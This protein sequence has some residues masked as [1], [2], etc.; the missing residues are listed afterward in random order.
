L[1]ITFVKAFAEFVSDQLIVRQL[2]HQSDLKIAT[3]QKI[4]GEFGR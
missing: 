1:L 2:F 4:Q 3:A